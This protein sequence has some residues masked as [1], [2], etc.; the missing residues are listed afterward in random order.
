MSVTLGF[1]DLV[2]YSALPHA[3]SVLYCMKIQPVMFIS[4]KGHQKV[5]Q[6]QCQ[7]FSIKLYLGLQ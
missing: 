4:L 3:F 7:Q 2:F 5:L 1:D 6:K